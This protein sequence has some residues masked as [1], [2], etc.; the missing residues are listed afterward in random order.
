[1]AVVAEEL[2]SEGSKIYDGQIHGIPSKT[3]GELGFLLEKDGITFA[4][5]AR[6]TGTIN[7]RVMDYGDEK[8]LKGVCESILNARQEDPK[9]P[10]GAKYFALPDDKNSYP[11]WEEAKV[12]FYQFLSAVSQAAGS[13][14]N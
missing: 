7:V 13:P 2:R 10:K 9:Y 3:N 5:Y 12:A 1:M 6:S 4:I 14:R 8:A 11:T